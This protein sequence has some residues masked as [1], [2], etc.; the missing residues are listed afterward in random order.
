MKYVSLNV[1]HGGVTQKLVIAFPNDLVHAEVSK[2]MQLCCRAHWKGAQIQTV[3]AGDI[4]I[5]D[6]ITGGHSESLG[7]TGNPEDSRTFLSSDH[8]GHFTC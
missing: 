4:W 8:G 1:K 7:L 2:A 6:A 3:N 5:D